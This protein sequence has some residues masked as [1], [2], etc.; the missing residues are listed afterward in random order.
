VATL[1]AGVSRTII[2]GC[3]AIGGIGLTMSLFIANLAFEGTSL[4]DSAK[5]GILGGSLIA[6]L[7]G[8]VILKVIAKRD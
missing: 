4:I 2:L 6:A 1:P 8:M 5:V 7:L 3:A